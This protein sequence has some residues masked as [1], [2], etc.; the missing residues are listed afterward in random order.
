[1]EHDP[2]PPLDLDSKPFRLAERQY[3]LPSLAGN[4]PR[5]RLNEHAIR[6]PGVIRPRGGE[7]R[8]SHFARR[9]ATREVDSARS[10]GNSAFTPLTL[11]PPHAFSLYL[12]A[13]P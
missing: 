5:R 1:M 13:V 6:R 9:R 11:R 3:D 2:P 7:L 8:I 12:A 4:P 10:V